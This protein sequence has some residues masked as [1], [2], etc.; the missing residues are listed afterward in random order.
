MRI[1][2]H[3]ISGIFSAIIG[4]S[5]SQ[6][7]LLEIGKLLNQGKSDFDTISWPPDIIVLPI[8]AASIAVGMVAT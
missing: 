4:W 1:Y 3:T 6:F 7:F 2:F 5:L 8:I